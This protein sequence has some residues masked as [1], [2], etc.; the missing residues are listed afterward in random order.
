MSFLVNFFVGQN[1]VSVNLVIVKPALLTP[2]LF[3]I[4]Y[5]TRFKATQKHI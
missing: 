1:F 2:A 4:V 3:K 5:C